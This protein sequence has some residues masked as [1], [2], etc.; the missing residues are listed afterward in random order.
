MAK[1]NAPL[2]ILSIP[3]WRQQTLLGEDVYSTTAFFLSKGEEETSL[4]SRRCDQNCDVNMLKICRLLTDELINGGRTLT[5]DTLT[6][7]NGLYILQTDS[8]GLETGRLNVATAQAEAEAAG[9][10]EQSC[11]YGMGKCFAALLHHR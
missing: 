11:F 2:D 1:N 9:F 4:K 8:N 5:E 7:P 3:E 6:A 10:N